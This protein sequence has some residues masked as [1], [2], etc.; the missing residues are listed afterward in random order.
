MAN[1]VSTGLGKTNADLAT[2][3][4]YADGMPVTGTSDQHTNCW[5]GA[6]LGPVQL[7]GFG[8]PTAV[9]YPRIY[10]ADG[11]AHDATNAATGCYLVVVSGGN[12]IDLDTVNYVRI[13]HLRIE[14][15]SLAGGGTG[16][17]CRTTN[18]TTFDSILVRITGGHVGTCYGWA[19]SCT[20]GGGAQNNIL[21][22]CIVYGTGAGT[23]EWG[24][25]F[26]SNSDGRPCT[27]ALYNNSAYLMLRGLYVGN[28]SSGAP[29]ITGTNNACLESGTDY[30]KTAASTITLTYSV[31]ADDTADD[32]GGAGNQINKSAAACWDTPSTNVIPLAA[33]PLENA[34]IAL[35]AVT[36]DAIGTARNDPPEVGA[37]ELASAGQPMP[38]RFINIRF[39]GAN[40]HSGL[41][42]RVG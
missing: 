23:A 8:T 33:G 19:S 15:P 5:T 27:A 30:G 41:G 4:V 24:F 34:G 37:I 40:L 21:K 26:Y 11:E 28:T 35:G 31:S 32:W 10:A 42:R 12:G 6:D 1:D 13:E 36:E 29:V 16:L 7:S 18:N 2:W 25:Y 3:E 39:A 9:L 38:K 20:T 22:N 17:F 14:M